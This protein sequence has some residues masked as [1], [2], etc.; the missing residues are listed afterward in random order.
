MNDIDG[1]L[2]EE[3]TT[4]GSGNTIAT[5]VATIMEPI[6]ESDFEELVEL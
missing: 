2:P 1:H 3:T 5:A 6:G 4:A